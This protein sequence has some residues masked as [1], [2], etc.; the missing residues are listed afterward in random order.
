MKMI[1]I[2][3]LEYKITGNFIK[4]ISLRDEFI[5]EVRD[6][7]RVTEII[8]K[9][10]FSADILTFS[11]HLNNLSPKYTYRMEWDNIAAVPISS[12]EDWFFK[13]IHPNTRNKIR[14]AKKAGVVVSVE[15]LTRKLAF[16]LVDIF[17]E[18]PIRRGSLYSYYGFDIEKV[19]K[20]WSKDSNRNDFLVAYYRDEIIGFIQVVYGNSCARTSGTVSKI[21][22][23]KNAPMNALFSKAV[24]I[25]AEKKIPFL[26]Y[27][28]YVYGKKGI[29][30]LTVFKKNNGFEK[31]NIPRYYIPLSAKGMLCL[32]LGFHHGII[33]V[34]PNKVYDT[35]ILLRSLWYE[36][37][38]CR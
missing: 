11:Q 30:S 35:G 36:R 15:S 26:V 18:T 31:M 17:N 6:P 22:H 32:K 24:E 37:T 28:K 3:G 10:N 38:Q 1:E 16:G 7:S 13:Q 14:K 23:R 5:D 25:C 9:R 2:E 27:G 8:K 21:A 12:Y 34:L 20:Q 29:D 4:T 19:E 33:S